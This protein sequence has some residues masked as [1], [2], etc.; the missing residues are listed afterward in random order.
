MHNIYDHKEYQ[1]DTL[2]S[3]KTMH[4]I[5]HILDMLLELL[6]DLVNADEKHILIREINN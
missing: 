4:Y 5:K 3:F 2:F 6:T 1:K